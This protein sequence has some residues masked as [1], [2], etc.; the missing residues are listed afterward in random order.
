MIDP[1]SI[2]PPASAL[3]PAAPPP[4]KPER[5][6]EALDLNAIPE[7]HRAEVFKRLEI[8]RAAEVWTTTPGDERSLEDYLRDEHGTTARSVQR[9]KALLAAGGVGTLAPQW[10]NPKPRQAF[11]AAARQYLAGLWLHENRPTMQACYDLL[12]HKAQKNG[13][14][15]GSYS[16]AK[17]YLNR[18]PRAAG[19]LFREGKKALDDK[20]I[21]SIR[22]ENDLKAN[23]IWECDHHQIDACVLLPDGSIVFP[24]YTCWRDVGS[25]LIVGAALCVTPS[26][27]SI[28]QAFRAAVA[29]HGLPGAVHLDNGRDFRCKMFAGGIRRFKVELPRGEYDGLFAALTIRVSWAIPR[30]AKSKTLERNFQEVR[31]RFAVWLRGY[32]GKNTLEKPEKLTIERKERDLLTYAELQTALPDFAN[33]WNHHES[34]ALAH[35][36]PAAEYVARLTIRRMVAA[37]ELKLFCLRYPEPRPVERHGVYLPVFQ[38]YFWNADLQLN[39]FGERVAVRYDEDDETKV[40][41]Y[42]Q[43]GRYIGIAERTGMASWNM[44]PEDYRQH[45]QP[46]RQI[47]EG[48]KEIYKQVAA[49]ITPSEREQAMLD[50]LGSFRRPI[51]TGNALTVQTRTPLA[52]LAADDQRRR[53]ER[54]EA[55]A[56]KRAALAVAAAEIPPA[57]GQDKTDYRSLYF[58][59]IDKI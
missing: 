10:K 3:V 33:W 30:N 23:A 29:E 21:P 11:C 43:A 13:W 14:K 51:D 54:A 20:V 56:R 42:D 22:R 38:A 19:V 8:I 53:R 49:P 59:V 52:E 58:S 9:W 27:I 18:I 6:R 40:Y 57:G 32:R 15:I 44:Q 50:Y 46:K 45:N 39:H 17:V 25:R 35:G 16:A 55:E 41:I 12:R 31:R 48:V 26:S 7:R 37:E 4:A 28:N 47:R 34:R 24:W 2:V 36:T 5:E 1:T